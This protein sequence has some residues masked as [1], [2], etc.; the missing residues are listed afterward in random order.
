MSSRSGNRTKTYQRVSKRPRDKSIMTVQ[1]I[2]ATSANPN[3]WIQYAIKINPAIQCAQ[4]FKGLRWK[5]NFT[6][7]NANM[8]YVRWAI[9]LLERINSITS[10]TM[11]NIASTATATSATATPAVT[12]STFYNPDE[13]VIVHGHGQCCDS[14]ALVEE[15]ETK[16]MRKL[17][18]GDNIALVYQVAGEAATQN[19][20]VIGAIQWVALS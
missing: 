4:T 15:G 3:E 17:K 18:P 6:N 7:T 10:A 19:C 12:L 5:L 8:I 16:A 1:D 9:V 2:L 14:F 11:A 13:K 20:V